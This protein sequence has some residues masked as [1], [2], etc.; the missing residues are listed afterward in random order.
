LVDP[1]HSEEWIIWDGAPD[2]Y[3]GDFVAQVS[4]DSMDPQIR[5]G[6]WCLFQPAPIEQAI[7]RPALVRLEDDAPDG[8]RFAI[9]DVHVEWAPAEDGQMVRVAIELRS[10]NP[11]HP[12]LR[13]GVGDQATVT[14]LA[15]VR[16]VLGQRLES[17]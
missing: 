2:F 17:S 16:Q 4:G 1:G 12:P 14:V 7:G 13:F 5:D 11:R 3:P 15:I 6:D 10:R 8:G 9:K